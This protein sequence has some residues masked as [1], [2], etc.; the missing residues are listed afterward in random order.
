MTLFTTAHASFKPMTKTK[1]NNT[2]VIQTE[3]MVDV[4]LSPDK[5]VFSGPDLLPGICLAPPI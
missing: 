2:E 1:D 5:I 4:K 3:L